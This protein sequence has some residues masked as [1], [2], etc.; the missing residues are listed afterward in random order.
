MLA[1]RQRE[2][3]QSSKIIFLHLAVPV[4]LAVSFTRSQLPD[5]QTKKLLL[6]N[7]FAA[8]FRP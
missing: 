1:Q 4:H 8:D 5:P 2:P 3:R 7:A 6:P